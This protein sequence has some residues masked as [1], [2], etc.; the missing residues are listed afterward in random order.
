MKASTRRWVSLSALSLLVLD[1][2]AIAAVGPQARG[3]LER[4]RTSSVLRAG[5]IV[6]RGFGHA[7]TRGLGH[8]TFALLTRFT[9]RS[10]SVYAFILSATPAVASCGHDASRPRPARKVM[11]EMRCVRAAAAEC[12]WSCPK[13][14]AAPSTATGSSGIGLPIP[15]LGMT[16]E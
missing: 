7:G 15:A 13:G 6:A 8:A 16:L 1:L 11:V 10:G 14:G 3:W 4:A 5:A 9:Q 12:P 2:G